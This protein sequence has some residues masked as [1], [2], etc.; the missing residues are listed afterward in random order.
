MWLMNP[1]QN[2]FMLRFIHGFETKTKLICGGF[3]HQNNTQIR[4]LIF[5]LY[6]L[7]ENGLLIKEPQETLCPRS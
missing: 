2:K 4:A 6:H 3:N 7:S 5:E 1:P